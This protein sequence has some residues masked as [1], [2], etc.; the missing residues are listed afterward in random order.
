MKKVIS[1]L[2]LALVLV[3]CLSITAMAYS[4]TSTAKLVNT[5][6]QAYSD[7]LPC[8]AAKVEAENSIYSLYDVK[9]TLML[10]TGDT[11]S[12]YGTVTMEP[13]GSGETGEWGRADVLYFCK[14]RL[15][16]SGLHNNGCTAE[17]DMTVTE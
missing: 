1:T 13:G 14:A 3:M 11:W 12:N 6:S 4:G 7:K 10:S 5:A 2:A 9:A 15:W 17:A 16:V 8:H